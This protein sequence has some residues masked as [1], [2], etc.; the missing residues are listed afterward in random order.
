MCIRD[1]PWRLRR[2]A[3]QHFSN[4]QRATGPEVWPVVANCVCKAQRFKPGQQPAASF[5]NEAP[6]RPLAHLRILQ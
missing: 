5:E 4:R 6:F 2:A 3:L 1:S